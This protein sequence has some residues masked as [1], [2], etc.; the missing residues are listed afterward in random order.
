MYKGR[1]VVFNLARLAVLRSPYVIQLPAKLTEI[2]DRIA[3]PGAHLV[4]SYPEG[5][6]ALTFT[7]ILSG[8]PDALHFFTDSP[9]DLPHELVITVDIVKAG[10]EYSCTLGPSGVSIGRTSHTEETK[11]HDWSDDPGSDQW[12]QTY[13]RTVTTAEDGTKLR[14]DR[15]HVRTFPD[16]SS[17]GAA[18]I[19]GEGARNMRCIYTTENW[20]DEPDVVW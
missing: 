2:R 18:Q 14:F 9:G 6:I 13:G 10:E 1:Q 8:L 3:S 20:I 16:G 7:N 5:T 19:A 11:L 12:W 17:M 15:I 4:M